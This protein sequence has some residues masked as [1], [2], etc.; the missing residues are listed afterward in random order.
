MHTDSSYPETCPRPIQFPD[1]LRPKPEVG[2]QHVPGE[3]GYL[4]GQIQ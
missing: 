2:V 4:Q 3:E 1:I